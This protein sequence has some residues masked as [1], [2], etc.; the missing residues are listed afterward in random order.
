MPGKVDR[1]MD[2]VACRGLAAA[3][4]SLGMPPGLPG[5]RSK[6]KEEGVE[7]KATYY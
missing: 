3:V 4:Q 7:A 1:K 2:R 5:R 6:N